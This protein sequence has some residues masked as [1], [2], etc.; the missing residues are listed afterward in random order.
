MSHKPYMTS[1]R[2]LNSP[3]QSDLDHLGVVV[4][5]QSV[6]SQIGRGDQKGAGASERIDNPRAL[7]C[8]VAD[9]ALG[10]FD[11]FLPPVNSV[12]LPS[13]GGVHDDEVRKLVELR[14]I[15]GRRVGAA[16]A[17]NHLRGDFLHIDVQP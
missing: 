1:T 6:A 11:R 13:I 3:C 15:E 8:A 14:T 9:E 16:Q 10:N 12:P 2:I 17:P 5:P 4:A 7:D